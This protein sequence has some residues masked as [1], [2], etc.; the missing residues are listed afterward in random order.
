MK[1]ALLAILLLVI[2][3]PGRS[4]AITQTPAKD[5]SVVT[6]TFVN[7]LTS[8]AINVQL[9]LNAIDV[10]LG[11]ITSSQ[12]TTIG[13]NL[14]NNNSGN[15][16]VGSHTPGTKL[17]VNGIIRTISG[18]VQFPD[19]SIQTSAATST[20]PGG[21]T[22][23]VQKN[24]SGAFAG[25][26]IYDVSSN[27]GVGSTHPG[28]LLDVNGITRI[29]GSSSDLLQVSLS[30]NV[31]GELANF[32]NITTG[33]YGGMSI[34]SSTTG[35]F[36]IYGNSGHDLQLGGQGN[37]AV[38]FS[39]NNVGISSATPGKA[40]DV[41]GA[42]RI[43]G[44]NSLFLGSD[45]KAFIGASATTT[46]DIKFSTNSSEVMRITNGGNVGVGTTTPQG[47]F[48][49]TSGNVGIGTWAPLY[50]LD[51]KGNINASGNIT[52]T[53]SPSSLN[54]S[55]NVGIGTTTPAGA[56]AVMSGNVGI[57]TWIPENPLEVI[58]AIKQ[59]RSAFVRNQYISLDAINQVMT[60]NSG[61]GGHKIYKINLA[62]AD[63]L[64]VN[65]RLDF[66]TNSSVK[67]SMAYDGNIGIGTITPSSIFE[68]GTQK[69]NVTSGGNVGI[70]TTTPMGG[71]TVMN[72]N[73][74]IGTWA[75]VAPL[76]V[77]SSSASD[78]ASGLIVSRFNVSGQYIGINERGGNDHW[79]S[80]RGSKPFYFTNEDSTSGGIG[81]EFDVN[82]APDVGGGTRAITV[83]N[84]GN[85]GIGTWT[86]G[87]LLDV[88]GTTNVTTLSIGG[89]STV[90][91]DGTAGKFSFQSRGGTLEAG[92][93]Y[94]GNGSNGVYGSTGVGLNSGAS[95]VVGW[96]PSNAS[97]AAD[98]AISRMSAGI[99]GVGTGA[100][101]SNAGTLT[102]ANIG[103]GTFDVTGGALIVKT[104]NVGIGTTTPQGVLAVGNAGAHS[105]QATCWTTG[106]A[107][108]YCTGVVGVGG[109]CSCT[110]L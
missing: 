79:I 29:T 83:M 103:I 28:Q 27:V 22:T 6:S 60:F 49:V 96:N 24:T 19:G 63:S 5:I 80:G 30:T 54:V 58:G 85:V 108:G 1:K 69:F 104:G 94:I 52:G 61:E 65:T 9:S 86:P 89:D 41:N 56:L 2:S 36:Q 32:G 18:G 51:V 25:A 34:S 48:V 45:N 66:A 67:M 38:T 21:V 92:A 46:P 40:L 44:T 98:V 15:V 100:A 90:V 101:G 14:Y 43:L 4:L 74:G 50:D 107:I 109:A 35:P 47:A 76:Q 93:F 55:G 59:M 31:T 3:F 95:A 106:G 42:A 81:F 110:A 7:C 72:G 11:Q 73:V 12:W 64:D 87:S 37:P 102:A 13:N 91:R 10:C 62:S 39:T 57:G 16:G 20:S 105:G 71:L 8:G 17:D 33:A 88:Q 23:Q 26:N 70:G 99:L 75:P 97:A 78:S 84:S 77:Y 68:V 82:N 53:F